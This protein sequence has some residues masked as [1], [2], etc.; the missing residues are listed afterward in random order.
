[1]L[2]SVQNPPATPDTMPGNFTE[3]PRQTANSRAY[4]QPGHPV[5]APA[6]YFRQIRYL[7]LP[8]AVPAL[9]KAL[10]G[11]WLDCGQDL[12][13]QLCEFGGAVKVWVTV[14]VAY[15]T[16]KPMANKEPFEQYLSAAPSRI[17]RSD[18]P[19]YA[20]ANRS[21][22]RRCSAI[23]SEDGEVSACRGTQVAATP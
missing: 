19:V 1:M 20:T 9:D 13:K 16:V 8:N 21:T 18:G 5:G 22:T 12:H 11:A 6:R 4:W 15:D 23:H 3:R 2:T 10:S 7:P 14:Q 17:F